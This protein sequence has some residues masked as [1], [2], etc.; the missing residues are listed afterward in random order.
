MSVT[1]NKGTV[2]N[3]VVEVDDKLDNLL[4]LVGT[5]P[6]FDTRLEDEEDDTIFI[7]QNVSATV[8]GLRAYCLIDTTQDIYIEGDYELYLHFTNLPE[9][10]RL[11][12]MKFTVD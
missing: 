12:P 8:D 11:G 9:A 3:V 5:I 6:M 10:P 7:E 1:L 4:T 2:E